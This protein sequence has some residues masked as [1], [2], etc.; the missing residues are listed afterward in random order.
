MPDYISD[1][2]RGPRARTKS[3]VSEV[4]WGG[5]WALIQGRIA[6]GSFGYRYPNP[7][8][9]G[10]GPFGTEEASFFAALRGDVPEL[11]QSL[12]PGARPPT[13]AMLDAIQFCYA[14]VAEPQQRGFHAFYGHFHLRFDREEGQRRLRG[15]VNRLFARNGLV[16]ELEAD[17]RM[18]RLAPQPL[19]SALIEAVFATGDDMLD[20]LLMAA[21]RKYLDPDPVM[22]Q[23]AL[24]KL[25]DAWERIKT[26]E[27]GKDKLQSVRA[28]LNH[29]AAKQSEVRSLIEAEAKEITRMG[30]EFRIRHSE[31][32]KV[33]LTR[34][35]DVDY[36]FH[37]GFALIRLLLK[38]TGR[39]G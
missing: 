14:V 32:G 36:F 39:G 4:A 2:K 1:R 33:P 20:D 37:R 15:D 13:L 17:G 6:D 12:G 11:G 16:Y 25:W 26:I 9:D 19:R 31:V 35:E 28:L 21:R 5:I 24:E 34:E 22:R 38:T 29:A 18:V 27:P 8:P 7:C 3:Q 23:E 30:N 10:E